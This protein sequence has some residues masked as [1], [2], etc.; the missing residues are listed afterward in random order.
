[1]ANRRGYHSPVKD[2][3]RSVTG[4]V[5]AIW[6]KT[7]IIGALL[8][9][10]FCFGQSRQPA[11]T[12]QTV[13]APAQAAKPAAKPAAQEEKIPEAAPDA[14]FPAVVARVNGKAI[15]G[16][17]LEQHVRDELVSIGN[18]QWKN[19]RAEYRQ[20]MIA[21]FM[22]SL[23]GEELIYQHARGGGM[24]LTAAEVKAEFENLKKTFANDAAMNA[25]LAARGMDRDALQRDLEK[26]LTVAKYIANTIDGKIAVAAPEITKYYNE[27]TDEFRHPDLIRTSHILIMVPEKS[28]ADQ[29][30]AARQRAEGLLAKARAG[31]D[32][33]KLARENS[34][35]PSASN[36]GD[37]GYTE[38]GRLASEYEDAAWALQTGKV[39]GVVR[40]QFGYHVIKTTDRK[41]AGLATLDE[42]RAQLTEF[43][44]AQKR[45]AEID[46][47]V[48]GLREK[49]DIQV[50]I[51][52][53]GESIAP[54]K[55]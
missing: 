13:Q 16:R 3:Q 35:D 32:F 48:N 36:G 22:G 18:P 50:F 14:L 17:Q 25:A 4:T 34:M 38:R 6:K 12:Q 19:L 37:I 9:A 20:E 52:A 41:K 44:K 24:K 5:K 46:K 45:E 53:L 8:F 26:S 43:L 27:N 28:T 2:Q 33:A 39:S 47:L 23:V 29:D 31:E 7:S 30:K 15:L 49:A 55:P 54:A 51:S 1:M 40:T 21:E 10:G 42:V 11:Q